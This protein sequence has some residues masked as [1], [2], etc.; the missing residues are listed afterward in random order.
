LTAD[1]LLVDRAKRG[2]RSALEEL[3]EK[4]LAMVFRFVTMRLGA[5]RADVEDVVQETLIAA[6]GS[7]NGLRAERDGAIPKWLLAIAR[8]KV[9]DHYRRSPA[10]TETSIDGEVGSAEH[11]IADVAEIVSARDRRRRVRQALRGLTPEQSE[12]VELRF[13]LG[14]DLAEVAAMTGRSVGAV[15]ALQHRGLASLQKLLATEALA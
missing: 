4:H 5:P 13:I 14:F 8:H 9:A 15:K 10:S 11:E 1:E 3:L 12:V 7:I 2:D 6:A